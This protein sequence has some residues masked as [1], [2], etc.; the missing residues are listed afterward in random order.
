MNWKGAF[1]SHKR[2]HKTIL[3]LKMNWKITLKQ[4]S[5]NHKLIN[6]FRMKSTLCNYLYACVD[7][8]CKKAGC[9]ATHIST[10]TS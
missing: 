10:L 5:C 7:R 2:G 3:G 8:F 6:V 1:R 4:L 9:I